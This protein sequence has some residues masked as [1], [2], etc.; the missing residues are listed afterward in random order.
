M[1]I[2]IY[3]RVCVRTWTCAEAE[4]HI[5]FHM[6]GASGNNMEAISRVEGIALLPKF[7]SLTV[8]FSSIT[9]VLSYT[10]KPIYDS[11]YRL[12]SPCCLMQS[13]LILPSTENN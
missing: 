4:Q 9:V 2:V 3:G 1:Y 10:L 7:H 13:L 8:Y 11:C 5:C 12:V 6:I